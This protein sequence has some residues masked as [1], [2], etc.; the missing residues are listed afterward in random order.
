MTSKSYILVLDAGTG[1]GRAVVFDTYGKEVSF[2][3]KEWLP[4]MLPQYPGSQVFD[5]HEAWE[6][7]ASCV[8]N[9][10]EKAA[11]DPA[12]IVAVSATSMR[13][14]MV[15]YDDEQREIWACPNIDARAEKETIE[16]LEMGIAEKLYRIGGDWLNIISP[17]RFWWIKKHEP[18]ILDKV[19][20]VSMV[21]DW[22]LFKLS[23]KIV[24]ESTAGSSSGIFDLCART[25]SQEA[26]EMCDLPKGIYPPVYEPGT[27]IGEVTKEAAAVTRLREGTPVVTGGAD[28]QLAVLG[29]GNI[30][31]NSWAVVAGT[32]WQ[33][34]VIWDTPLIDRECRPRTLCHAIPGQWMTEGIGFLIG[35]QARWFRDG[36]CQEE[37]KRAHREGVDPYFLMEK[38]AESVP[39]G[40][41]D[42]IGLFSDLHRSKFWKHAAPSFVNFDIYNPQASGKA[43]CIRALWEAAAYVAYGNLLVLEELTGK[44]PEQVTFCGGSSKGFL[45]PQIMADVFGVP[46]KVPTVK[47]ATA[48]GCAMCVGVGTG[49]FGNFK[50]VVESWFRVEKVFQPN[51]KNHEQYLKHYDRWREVFVE[52]MKIVN[53]GL[54]KPMWTAPGI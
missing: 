27:V 17:P 25:W 36:F 41:N 45:W 23:G 12:E 44:S 16:L 29:V 39:P 54:L 9:A 49:L 38:L 47:E 53:Q 15:L 20:R 51:L 19:S 34:T 28:T 5:T 42:I 43:G 50:E 2:A 11:I 22:V 3:Q 7:L 13:E 52:F 33:T 31:P 24:T 32:F 40:S 46:M 6:I 30:V 26:I 35:Q 4:R 8:R 10:L 37:I 1:S 18:Q 14:G 21:S 48:L